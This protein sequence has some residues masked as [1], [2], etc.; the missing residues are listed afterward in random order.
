VPAESGPLGEAS[1]DETSALDSQ[2]D[3]NAKNST[4]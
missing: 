3:P 4:K 1:F 2:A